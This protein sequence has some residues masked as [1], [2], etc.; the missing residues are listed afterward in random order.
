M[1]ENEGVSLQTAVPLP[2]R[3]AGLARLMPPSLSCLDGPDGGVV[4]LPSDLAW[5]GRTRFDLSDR[6][7]RY[8]FH[9][10]VLTSA[11]T[12]EHYTHWLNA[13]L[14]RSD[15]ARL[16]LPRALRA[17]WQERFP[18]LAAGVVRSA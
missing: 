11:I 10:T 9:M 2:S 15:W 13:D 4:E 3:W 5:S 12:A 1:G 18:E 6:D 16:R 17:L 7:Q 14:L 8:L